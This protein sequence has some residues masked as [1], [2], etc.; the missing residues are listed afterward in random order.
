[1]R[2]PDHRRRDRRLVAIG[3]LALLALAVA[4]AATAIHH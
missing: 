1:M 4:Y 3:R 2:A